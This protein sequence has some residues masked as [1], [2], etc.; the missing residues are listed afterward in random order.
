MTRLVAS[1]VLIAAVG[2]AGITGAFAQTGG[3]ANPNSGTGIGK[4]QPPPPPPPPPSPRQGTLDSGTGIGKLKPV[5]SVGP[6]FA[7]GTVVWVGHASHRFA[8]RHRGMRHVFAVRR[9]TEF[10]IRHH[11]VSFSALHAGQRATVMFHRRH[12]HRVA[13]RVMIGRR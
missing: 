11:R 4:L 13:D 8:L 9:S 10:R 6:G 1:A 5:Q 3:G 7:H 12:H 2:I